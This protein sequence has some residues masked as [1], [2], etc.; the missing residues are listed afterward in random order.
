MLVV[1]AFCLGGVLF[2]EGV[3]AC[4]IRAGDSRNMVG[5]EDFTPSHRK[6][7]LCYFCDVRKEG[8]EV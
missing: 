5:A 8:K 6:R 1:A 3:F 7:V 4:D 2:C